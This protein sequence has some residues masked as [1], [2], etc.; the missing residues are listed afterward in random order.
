MIGRLPCPVG[1][2]PLAGAATVVAALAAVVV[3]PAAIARPSAVRSHP[4]SVDLGFALAVGRDGK[5]VVAG[6]S[7]RA[8]VPSVRLRVTRPAEGSTPAS[9]LAAEC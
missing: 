6:V 8:R 4:H 5:P 2:A 1:L 3:S 9:E 7:R